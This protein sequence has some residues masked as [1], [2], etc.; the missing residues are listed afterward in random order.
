MGA[1]NDATH[2]PDYASTWL[3]A[4][5][6]TFDITGVQLEVGDSASD[7]EHRSFQQELTLCQRY[8]ERIGGNGGYDPIG[9]GMQRETNQSL[10]QSYFKVP[11]R[12][13]PT[14]TLH[15]DVI[16]TDRFAFDQNVS[17]LGFAIASTEGLHGRADH[18]SV[19]AQRRP[20]FITSANTGTA[21][22]ITL[23]AEL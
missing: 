20:I 15:G 11:K 23:D 18:S 5:A 16:T 12:A 6:S 9:N 17:S 13:T 3:T 14:V 1:K 10:F 4:G 8:F 19:G 7:F 21:G 22:S 2:S